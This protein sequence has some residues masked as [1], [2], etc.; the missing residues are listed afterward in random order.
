MSRILFILFISFGITSNLLSQIV[1]QP[2]MVNRGDEES[3]LIEVGFRA[4]LGFRAKDRFENNLE[5]FTSTFQPGV[6]SRS[7]VDGFRTMTT[8]ELLLRTGIGDNQRFGI[9]LGTLQY[10]KSSLTE[11]T[12]DGFYTRLNFNLYTNYLIFTYHYLW[13]FHKNWG[14]EGGMGFGA[15]ET[16]WRSDGYAISASEYFPQ[17]G[18]LR[19][20]GI[21]FRAEASLNYRV[22]ELFL[23]QFGILVG[24]NQVA[25]FSGSWNGS[26]AT[27]YIREDGRTTPLSQSRAVDS[28]VLTN[29]FARSL[30]MNT[31]YTSL[32][33][34]GMLRFSY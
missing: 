20:N 7:Q 8:G 26:A 10:D 12:S 27:F 13:D 30:D 19:G 6:Y 11:L 28:I 32:Y 21:S 24:V 16:W 5:S 29:Q 15:N 22:S 34:S 1:L 31:S 4:G 3:G 17:K 14:I 23:I 18:T 25:S 33:F 2:G 9:A